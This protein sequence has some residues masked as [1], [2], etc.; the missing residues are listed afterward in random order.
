MHCLSVLATAVQK[1]LLH[2]WPFSHLTEQIK[3]VAHALGLHYDLWPEL[4]AGELTCPAGPGGC[5]RS[6]LCV[7]TAEPACQ[8]FTGR[9]LPNPMLTA[10]QPDE[11]H[12]SS[13]SPTPLTATCM[14]HCFTYH[15]ALVLFPALDAYHS[16]TPGSHTAWHQTT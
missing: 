5:A 7:V 6:H 9:E 2:Q 3:A 10:R 8:R 13:N 14:S 11:L 12:V 16:S 15:R 4:S 1:I